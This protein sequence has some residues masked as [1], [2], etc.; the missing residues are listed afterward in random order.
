MNSKKIIL[1]FVSAFVF[2]SSC[3]RSNNHSSEI[4]VLENLL[5]EK[6]TEIQKLRDKTKQR[7]SSFDGKLIHM[8]FFNLKND[9]DKKDLKKFI[10]A[11]EGLR[12]IS[13]VE[14]LIYGDFLDVGDERSM[15]SL[16]LVIRLVFKDKSGLDDYQKNNIHL[17]AK[18]TLKPFL[19]STPVTYD[20]IATE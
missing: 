16:D 19:E 20:Y 18:K 7:L 11:I 2:L 15:D 9:L 6:T 4:I 8:V 1:L 12:N 17:A 13:A 10:E 3:K 5:I 14:N